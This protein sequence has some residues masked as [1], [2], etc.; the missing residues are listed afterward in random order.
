MNIMANMETNN[1][2]PKQI[3]RGYYTLDVHLKNKYA[4][5]GYWKKG[6]KFF[7][8]EHFSGTKYQY[9]SVREFSHTHQ[10]IRSYEVARWNV[11]VNFLIPLI[12]DNKFTSSL[13]RGLLGVSAAKPW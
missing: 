7:V 2:T 13:E 9:S 6:T 8:D 10:F 5:D 1:Y 3:Q 12:D 4:L 11:F